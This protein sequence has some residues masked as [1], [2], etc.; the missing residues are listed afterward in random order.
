MAQVSAGL[1]LHRRPPD[2]GP[3]VLLARM[4]GP[5]WARRERAWTVPKGLVEA[6][7]DPH[8][9]ALREFA[10]ELGVAPPASAAPDVALGHVTQSGGKVV[11]AWARAAD[12]DVAAL[13]WRD[14]DGR[15][16]VST[17]LVEWPPRS[18]R[19]LEVPE[20]DQA[21]WLGLDE[22]RALVVAAQAELLD[23]LAVLLT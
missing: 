12:L 4:G 6:G 16:L 14:D 17:A 20:V 23:R 19:T 9:A 7:E 21:R 22:A 5:F 8:A 3:Q 10:E 11:H 15:W 18:G 2:G 1:L 13:R